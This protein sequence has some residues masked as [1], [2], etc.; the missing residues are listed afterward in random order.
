MEKAHK[1]NR[2]GELS[3]FRA[4]TSMQVN[5][6]NRWLRVTLVGPSWYPAKVAL[7]CPLLGL[8]RTSRALAATSESGTFGHRG[9]EG[10]CPPL[11]DEGT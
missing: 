8:E 4:R 7:R 5:R 11:G 1:K 9:I 3:S 6:A 10:Q 2:K